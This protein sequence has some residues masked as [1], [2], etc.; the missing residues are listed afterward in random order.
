MATIVVED[1]TI[2]TGANSYLSEADLTTYATD[3]GI[4]LS[5]TTAVLLIQ[6]MDY[7]ESQ[8]FKGTK[9]TSGQ[10]LQWPRYGVWV[11]SYYVE[12]TTIPQLLKD[13]LA[14]I[15]IGIYGG[16]NP[17]ANED[18]ETIREKVGDIEVEYS[19]GA[20]AKTYLAAAETKLKKL[21]RGG[22]FGVKVIRG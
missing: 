22:E 12:S 3:R 16:N 20:R 11:D 19:P 5:G 15:A 4:T 21:L 10:S 13:A 9:S 18:R 14:E 6:A 2:V 1:G 8:P 7:I 17:L